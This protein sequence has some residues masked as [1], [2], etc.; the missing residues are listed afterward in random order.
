LLG[1]SST[2]SAFSGCTHLEKVELP[3]NL[4]TIYNN[5]FVGCIKL[6]VVILKRSAT[7]LTALNNVNAFPTANTNLKFYVPDLEVSNYQGTTN[8]SN[9]AY[10]GKIVS[11][12]TL[13]SADLPSKW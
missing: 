12:N 7:P 9:T 4:K 1:S 3:D 11:I 8:W 6:Q 13:D 5:S 10:S 2:G